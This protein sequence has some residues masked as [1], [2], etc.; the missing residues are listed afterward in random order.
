MSA[1]I[2]KLRILYD[3]MHIEIVA[4][5]MAMDT[6]H[7]ITCKGPYSGILAQAAPKMLYQMRYVS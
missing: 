5:D 1:Y 2:R 7:A 4:V 3:N 6:D